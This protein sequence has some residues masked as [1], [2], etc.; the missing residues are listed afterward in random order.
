[1]R[2]AL[3]FGSFNP[4]HIGHISIARYVLACPDI[5]CFRFVLSPHNPL[6]DI[7]I[8]SDPNERL[9][10]LRKEIEKLNEDIGR[11]TNENALISGKHFEVSDVEFSLPE[12][13]YT[14]HTLAYLKEQ[15]PGTDFILIIGADNLAIIEKWYN[16][17]KIL[18]EFE[19]WVYPRIGH[20]APELCKKYG[21]KYLNAPRIDISSTEIRNKTHPKPT[22]SPAPSGIVK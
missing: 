7:G 13:L 2:C 15:E 11:E 19:V 12:P 3:Y 17:Q 14:Y 5:D 6:K 10:R 18:A 9:N 1:M 4:L 21:V 20:N 22:S 8:L 16:W